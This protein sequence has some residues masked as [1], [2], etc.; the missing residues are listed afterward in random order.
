MTENVRQARCSR[1]KAVGASL[2]TSDVLLL[3]S[4]RV[5]ARAQACVKGK[6]A[7]GQY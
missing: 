2:Y 1:E 7:V 5:K 6:R 3:P 4:I